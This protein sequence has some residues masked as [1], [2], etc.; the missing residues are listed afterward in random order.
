MAFVALAAVTFA[1]PPSIAR[2]DASDANTPKNALHKVELWLAVAEPK[3]SAADLDAGLGAT[4]AA[5][6]RMAMLNTEMAAVA[7]RRRNLMVQAFGFRQKIAELEAEKRA[8]SKTENGIKRGDVDARIVELTQKADQ[9]DAQTENYF[10]HMQRISEEEMGIVDAI[11]RLN[12]VA[13]MIRTSSTADDKRKQKAAA[14]SVRT[15]RTYKL[16]ASIIMTLQLA[17]R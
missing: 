8:G 16:H 7:T 10:A 5:E 13:E 4:T 1:I 6:E 11:G 12:G 2:A 9:L 14:L 3:P 17:T 15:T